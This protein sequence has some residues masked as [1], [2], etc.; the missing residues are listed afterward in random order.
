M[1]RLRIIQAVFAFIGLVLFTLALR[2]AMAAAGAG[3]TLLALGA[4]V[5]AIGGGCALR[6]AHRACVREFAPC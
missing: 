6:L 3:D 5:E 4:L 2:H 1:T